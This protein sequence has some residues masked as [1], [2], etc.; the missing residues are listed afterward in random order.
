M[1]QRRSPDRMQKRSQGRRTTA[2]AAGV[3]V[4]SS[5]R[6]RYVQ[7]SDDAPSTFSE[8]GEALSAHGLGEGW[9][10]GEAVAS[11]LYCDWRSPEDFQQTI[12]TAA[13]TDGDADS[14]ASISGAFNGAGLLPGRWRDELENA[15]SL[16]QLATRLWQASV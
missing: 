6:D 13:K 3:S 9:A 11:A 1:K 5:W 14:I 15:E 2:V 12:L 10:A 4:S 7:V 8:P 16:V